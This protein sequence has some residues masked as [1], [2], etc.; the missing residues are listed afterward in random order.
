M[1]DATSRLAILEI[2]M[3]GK[4]L[5]KGFFP[6]GL[7]AMAAATE[8]CSG[9]DLAA[10]CNKAALMAIREYLESPKGKVQGYEGFAVGRKHMEQA[11]R[12]IQQQRAS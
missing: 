3:R 6:K 12:I 2:H 9:A 8:G 11:Q 5:A 1:P 10:I 4:P 7:Q